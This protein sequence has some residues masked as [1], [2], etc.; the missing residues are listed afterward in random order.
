MRKPPTPRDIER[1][2]PERW[3]EIAGNSLVKQAFRDFVRCGQ[4][5]NTLV[6]GQTR[7]AKTRTIYLFIMALFCKNRTSTLDPCHQCETCRSLNHAR[8]EH[9]GLWSTLSDSNFC[10]VPV[11]C[12]NVTPEELRRLLNQSIDE[13][14]PTVVYLDEVAAL[15]RRNLEGIVL[16][17]IDELPIVWI[18]SAITVR[19]PSVRGKVRRTASLSTPLRARFGLKLGTALPT[20]AELNTWLKQRCTEWEIR[21]KE[22]D[23]ISLLVSRTRCRVVLVLHVL[24]NA[25]AKGRILTADDIRGFNFDAD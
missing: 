21:V 7:T 2:F 6:T 9:A 23:A 16:K 12:E 19:K 5:S 8:E 18:A 13:S 22:E 24:A 20:E 3:D 25:V 10:Y 11:D 1:W 4:G 15:G 14:V 17:P